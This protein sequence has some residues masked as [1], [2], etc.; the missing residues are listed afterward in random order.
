MNSLKEC[1]Q[2]NLPVKHSKA[3]FKC[4]AFKDNQG[5]LKLAK[6]PKLRPWTR[7]INIQYHHIWQEVESG[8]I[9][10]KKVNTVDQWADI[11]TKPIEE[12]NFTRTCEKVIGW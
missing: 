2:N 8:N 3:E 1:I 4:M 5:A 11:F 6:T 9:T 7:H 10:L 12:K